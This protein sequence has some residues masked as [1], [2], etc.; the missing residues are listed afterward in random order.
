MHAAL[1]S[2]LRNPWTKVSTSYICAS[3]VCVGVLS[4]SLHFWIGGGICTC[5]YLAVLAPRS[6]GLDIV[7]TLPTTPTMAARPMHVAL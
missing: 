5:T 6:H 2:A 1:S 7:V 3:R 4:S